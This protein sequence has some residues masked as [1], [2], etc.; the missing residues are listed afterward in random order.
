MKDL[1]TQ[2]ATA[3][4]AAEQSRTEQI[5][6]IDATL[7]HLAR[8]RTELTEQLSAIVSRMN[9]AFPAIDQQLTDARDRLE[10][11]AEAT[12]ELEDIRRI[13]QMCRPASMRA[14]Q[15]AAEYA[16]ASMRIPQVATAA[17]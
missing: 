3:G 7:A 13:A 10:E 16:P 17:E 14:P 9:S 2:I 1:V 4:L 11:G 15:I 5:E 12:R 6:R 8:L